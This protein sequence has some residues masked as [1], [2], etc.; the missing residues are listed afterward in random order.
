[1]KRF[2]IHFGK[3]IDNDRTKFGDLLAGRLLALESEILQ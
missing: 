3:L 2:S 1:M